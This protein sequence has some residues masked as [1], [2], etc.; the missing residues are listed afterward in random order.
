MTASGDIA[1]EFSRPL[2]LE[3]LNLGPVERAL[4]A[5]ATECTALATRFG[6]PGVVALSGSVTVSRPGQGPAIRVAG[7]VEAEVTQTCVVSLAPF[8]Q[9][10]AEDFVQRYTLEPVAEPPEVF[11]DPDA[12]EPPEPLSGDS[13]DLGEVL[14]E[15]LALALDPYPRAPGAAL[16]RVSFGTPDAEAEVEAAARQSPFAVLKD[17]KTPGSSG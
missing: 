12:E 10:V 15:Q 6:I 17:L 13:L 7:R 1:P 16:S 14:A 3:R 8:T 4:R 2:P 11:S 9:A 5:N